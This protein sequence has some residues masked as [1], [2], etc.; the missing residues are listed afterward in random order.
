MLCSWPTERQKP[1]RPTSL[2]KHNPYPW[3]LK[4]KI[5]KKRVLAHH[6]WA[7]FLIPPLPQD[8]WRCTRLLERCPR[9]TH[10]P[11]LAPH[12]AACSCC[13]SY[14][15]FPLCLRSAFHEE[16]MTEN[17]MNIGHRGLSLTVPLWNK[18]WFLFTSAGLFPLGGVYVLFFPGIYYRCQKLCSLHM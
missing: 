15:E 13:Q 5:K 11:V 1:K 14:R 6:G 12:T 3:R 9:I 8:M 2:A 16:D 4:R 17:K 18:S 7:L 10:C